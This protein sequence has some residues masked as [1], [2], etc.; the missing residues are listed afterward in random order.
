MLEYACV[1]GCM[2][3][4]ALLCPSVLVTTPGAGGTAVNLA[5]FPHGALNL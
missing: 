4:S 3:V 5:S 2:S 1:K